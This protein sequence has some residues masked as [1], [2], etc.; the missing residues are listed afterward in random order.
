M[1]TI[2][3]ILHFLMKEVEGWRKLNNFLSALQWRAEPRLS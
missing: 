1:G 3:F 2:I